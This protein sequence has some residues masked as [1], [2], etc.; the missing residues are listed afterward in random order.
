MQQNLA[1]LYRKLHKKVAVFTNKAFA[2]IT[3]IGC[4]GKISI[5]AYPTTVKQLKYCLKHAQKRQ[6]KWLVLGRG[7]NFLASDD[8]FVG[9]VV[10]TTKMAKIRRFATTVWCQCGAN[11]ARVATFCAQRGLSGVQCWYCLPATVGGAVV[12][13]AG[14]FGQTTSSVV[15]KVWYLDGNRLKTAK[16]HQCAFGRRTST[17]ADTSKVVVTAKLRL[18]RGDSK[19]IKS[20]QKQMMERKRATQPIGE[21]SFGSA[22][23]NASGTASMLIDKA[24]LKNYQIGGAK[25]SNIHAGFVINIDKS[26]SYDIYLLLRHIKEQ[27]YLQF[28]E[29]LTLEVK[30]TGFGDETDNFGRLPH[31]H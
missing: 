7:S 12:M 23:F 21:K 5:L 10:C 17:F 20:Q 8:D 29:Q 14:C 30:T 1:E 9:L 25:V 15:K 27:V 22:F 2:D 13:N 11:T 16:L 4:G 26:S 31:P 19:Q 3:T 28:G 24:G 18:K 6:V